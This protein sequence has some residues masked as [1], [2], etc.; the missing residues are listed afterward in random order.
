[1]SEVKRT[2][3][4]VGYMGKGKYKSKIKGVHTPEYR[5]WHSMINRCYNKKRLKKFTWYSEC[6]V[7]DDW[8]NFQIFAEWFNKTRPKGNFELDKDINSKG[9]KIYSPETCS[10]VTKKKNSSYAHSKKCKFLSPEGV[11]FD[12][13]NVKAFALKN[14]LNQSHLNQVSLGKAKHHKGWR[15]YQEI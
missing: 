11:V 8:H 2:V 10:W 4:G 5:C 12:V 14:N 15:L 9:K 13:Y 7:I 3:C 1:M 6:S